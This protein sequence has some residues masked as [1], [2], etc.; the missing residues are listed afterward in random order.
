MEPHDS[1]P[2]AAP[3]SLPSAPLTTWGAALAWG[4]QA[5]TA[6]GSPS[7]RLDALSLLMRALGVPH[8]VIEGAPDHALS[9]SIAEQY[10]NWI[11][12]RA[13]GEPVAY[14]TGH[15]AFMGL[16]LF[17]DQWVFLVRRS[18]EFLVEA[19]LEIAR[20]RPESDALLAAD[21]GTGCGAIA[22][23]L[24]SLEPR[25]ARAYA[26]DASAD[27]LAVARRNGEHHRMEGRIVWLQG[28]LLSP[29][30]EP[31][32]LIISNLPTISQGVALAPEV[33]RYEPALAF[34]G[35]EDGLALVRRLLG[36]APA[37]LRPGG[38]I[39]LEIQ[40]EQGAAVRDMLASAFPAAHVRA[41]RIGDMDRFMIAQLGLDDSSR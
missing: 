12:R 31:V 37:K 35:G 34:F 26:V 38:A 3:G 6:A 9:P 28:D 23:A 21:V 10:A 11:A 36:Q 22:L 20:L 14:I 32:D 30:P 4:T 8:A 7:P 13:E 39:A 15:K 17:V 5:L 18:T 2:G 25:F 24:A 41:V 29:V 1:A 27:A 40:P 19:A 16:D 33:A